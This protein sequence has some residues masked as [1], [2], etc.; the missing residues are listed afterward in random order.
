MGII[1]TTQDETDKANASWDRLEDIVSSILKCECMGSDFILYISRG[2]EALM[3]HPIY[4]GLSTK[5][6]SQLHQRVCGL[7]HVNE[8]V[9][10][11]Y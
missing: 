10:N 3:G 2:I 4:S 7:K 5:D 8:Q 9:K 1:F 6:I 11:E